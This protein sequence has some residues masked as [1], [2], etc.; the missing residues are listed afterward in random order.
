MHS[1]NQ[2]RKN[3]LPSLILAV[4]FWLGGGFIFFTLPPNSILI[5][6]IFLILTTLAIFLTF[7]FILR[8]SK[9]GLVLTLGIIFLVLLKKIAQ[10]TFVN[11]LLVFAILITISVFLKKSKK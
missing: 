3:Y 6:G 10:L 5:I 7:S 8:S 4:L 11:V 9:R 1:V 2:I